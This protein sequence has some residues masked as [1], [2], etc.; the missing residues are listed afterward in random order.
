MDALLSALR[1]DRAVSHIL[2]VSRVCVFSQAS[3]N[4]IPLLLVLGSFPS[5]RVSLGH[6][7]AALPWLGSRI[8]I[9]LVDLFQSEIAA[10]VVE[11]EYQEHADEIA[12]GENVSVVVVN[13]GC[14]VRSEEGQQKVPRPVTGGGEGGGMRTNSE[15]ED[16]A[17]SDPNAGSP[18]GSETEDEHAGGKNEDGT[19]GGRILV[20]L[21]TDGS[22]D[23]EP[24]ALPK[25]T[26]EEGLAA[27]VTFNKPE[28]WEGRD[29]VDA[30][31]NDLG[32]EWVGETDGLEDGGSVVEEV[33]GASELL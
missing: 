31:E 3:V 1:P 27:T 24:S 23:D 17:D 18:G 11:E 21:G 15:R 22:E 8:E 10:F 33:V 12:S 4:I 29:N 7:A 26:D 16:L 20:C 14:D 5:A 9:H 6:P 32:D 28:T 13:G 25:T 30:A 19:G 2:N